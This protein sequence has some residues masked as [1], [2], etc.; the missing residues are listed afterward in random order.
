MLR[1]CRYHTL[2]KVQTDGQS[3]A[4]KTGSSTTSITTLRR[5]PGISLPAGSNPLRLPRVANSS[6][7]TELHFSKEA[8]SIALLHQQQLLQGG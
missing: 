3:T 8:D 4:H 7:A 2:A 6:T 1:L 5:T